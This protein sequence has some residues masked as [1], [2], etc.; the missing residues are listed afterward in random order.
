RG[1][2]V[3]RRT[4]RVADPSRTLVSLLTERRAGTTD[5]GHALAVRRPGWTRVVI[6]ARREE[7]HTPSVHVVDADERVIDTVPDNA[8]LRAVG[9][10]YRCAIPAPRFDE[11]LLSSPAEAG[12][13][14]RPVRYR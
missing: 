8:R 3:V 5:E 11:R 14:R 12:H 9:R 7:R 1:Q 2:R 10:P 13:Y 6:D 4:V